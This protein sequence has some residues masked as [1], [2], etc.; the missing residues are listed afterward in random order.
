MLT[1]SIVKVTKRVRRFGARMLIAACLFILLQPAAIRPALSGGTA[2][3]SSAPDSGPVAAVCAY[4]A[5]VALT[6]DTHRLSA[7]AEVSLTLSRAAKQL[8]LWLNPVLTVQNLTLAGVPVSFSRDD[9]RLTINLPAEAGAG[10]TVRITVDYAGE[11]ISRG[12]GLRGHVGPEGI[13]LAGE[14]WLP[15]AAASC[16]EVPAELTVELPA[17]YTLVNRGRVAERDRLGDRQVLHLQTSDLNLI[18]GVY[19]YRQI[20][21]GPTTVNLYTYKA[22]LEQG[23]IL[24]EEVP[25]AFAFLR[26]TLGEAPIDVLT[27]VNMPPVPGFGSGVAYEDV[28]GLTPTY[29]NARGYDIYALLPHEL[30][31]RWQQTRL[32]SFT[33]PGSVWLTEATA[34]YVSWMY[35]ADRFGPERFRDALSQAAEIAWRD[36]TIDGAGSVL[37]W[38][39]K[40]ADLRYGP[41][42]LRGAWALHRFR[43]LIGEEKFAQYLR[44]HLDWRARDL[45]EWVGLCSQL[46]GFNVKSYFDYWLREDDPA[47]AAP[48]APDG[49]L[50]PPDSLG[51]V[52]E[53][54]Q[55]VVQYD[56]AKALLTGTASLTLH[57][58]LGRRPS[59]RLSLDGGLTV[60]SVLVRGEPTPFIQSA[61]DLLVMPSGG[62]A[63]DEQFTVVVSY[64]GWPKVSRTS[65][66]LPARD[67]WY[68]SLTDLRWPGRVLI[69]VPTGVAIARPRGWESRLVGGEIELVPENGAA[70]ISL[71]PADRDGVKL[72]AAAGAVI[73]LLI[74]ALIARHRK[75]L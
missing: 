49:A 25:R 67:L 58:R 5:Q 47:F 62:L 43:Q 69:R 51:L 74:G 66:A 73:A 18:A 14:A 35:L 75:R 57:N 24:A 16:G 20:S 38:E 61:R 27:I 34:T 44:Q 4:R 63:D 22:Y 41:V 39:A 19:E 50:P 32:R 11:V 9:E 68:P 59:F 60:A 55:L 29:R 36:R 1:S 54:G 71:V 8:V 72:A 37:A 23:L 30:T 7:Q 13:F 70:P 33:G 52:A 48:G 6:P 40:R 31:H 10:S 17:G 46:A 12:W 2:A 42:Y 26:R 65:G 53:D 21:A 3:P 56:P 28:V 45:D 64:A 15:R